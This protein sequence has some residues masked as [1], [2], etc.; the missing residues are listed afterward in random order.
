MTPSDFSALLERAHYAAHL[1]GANL[2]ELADDLATS[3]RWIALGP[4]G[5]SWVHVSIAGP[6]D[7]GPGVLPRH[8]P[9]WCHYKGGFFQRSENL[10]TPAKLLDTAPE[11]P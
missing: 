4:Q 6:I 2:E 5:G 9:P 3:L 1:P 8:H 7:G 11:K 10:I